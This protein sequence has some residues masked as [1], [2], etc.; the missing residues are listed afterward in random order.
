MT[1]D[2]TTTATA[3]LREEHQLI[4][5]VAA[6]LSVALAAERTGRPLD[7]EAV[8]ECITFF[9]LFADACH[10]GK[11]EDLLFPSLEAEGLPQNAGPIAVMLAEH[12]QGRALVR[13]MA[14]SLDNARAGHEQA[15]ID[16]RTAAEG[17]VN[18]IAAHISKEDNML[19]QMADDLIQG[20][21]CRDLCARYDEVCHRRFDGRTK[22]ELE[23]LGAAILARN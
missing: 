10:H 18:L 14:A 19:F 17:F 3:L 8:S 4:L 12:Q 20:P 1:D 13:T 5:K 7:Y 2:H 22:Q 16:L 11:E 15:G 9:R 23:R 21:T 6:W